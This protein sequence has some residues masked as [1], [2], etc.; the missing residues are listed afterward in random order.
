MQNLKYNRTYTKEAK[1]VPFMLE[2]KEKEQLT[3]NNIIQGSRSH[4]LPKSFK[5]FLPQN[6]QRFFNLI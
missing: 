3:S 1:S 6:T 4:I 5:T 2:F